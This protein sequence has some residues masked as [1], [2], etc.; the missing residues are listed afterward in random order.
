MRLWQE[1]RLLRHRAP[2]LAL[3]GTRFLF[4]DVTSEPLDLLENNSNGHI[5]PPNCYIFHYIPIFCFSTRHPLDTM[6]KTD[7]W[8]VVAVSDF[9]AVFE[10][11]GVKPLHSNKKRSPPPLIKLLGI[12]QFSAFGFDINS[13]LGLQ[14]GVR[15][16]LPRRSDIL[17]LS[18]HSLSK[19][20]TQKNLVHGCS[21]VTVTNTQDLCQLG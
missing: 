7:E 10:A 15:S 13:S 3:C 1:L 4:D 5:W 16:S 2:R 9:D 19:E 6:M 12:D 8:Q 14:D 11:R 17:F 20:K 21:C 18:R